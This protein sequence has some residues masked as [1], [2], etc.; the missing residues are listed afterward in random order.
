[1]DGLAF[2]AVVG[3]YLF[4]DIFGGKELAKLFDYA[5]FFATLNALLTINNALAMV[6]YR[7]QLLDVST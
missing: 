5:L 4:R 6:A 1:M 2:D 3:Q 7:P